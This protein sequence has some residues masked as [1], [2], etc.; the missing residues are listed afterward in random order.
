MSDISQHSHRV[1][2]C[3]MILSNTADDDINE[4]Y[5]L[6]KGTIPSRCGIDNV[7]DSLDIVMKETESS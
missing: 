2:S 1:L 4:I 5:E 6:H 3:D 7:N